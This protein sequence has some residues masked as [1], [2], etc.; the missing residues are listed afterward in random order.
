MALFLIFIG[1]V[2]RIATHF[3]DFAPL[4][5]IL[6]Y[7]PHIPNFAPIAAIA[8]FGSVY[9]NKKYALVLPLLAMLISDI[10]IGFYSP[11]IMISVYSSFLLIGLIGL[12]L[13]E[14]K[15][16]GNILGGSLF[17][18][19]IFFLVTNFAMWAIP[20]SLYPHTLQ[21]LINCYTMGL[22]F[23]RYTILGDL[24]YTSVF[25]GSMEVVLYAHQKLIERRL[26]VSTI[27]GRKKV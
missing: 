25:F 2:L 10:F 15:T 16:V 6:K 8:L 7:L 4:A 20:H 12:Y 5:D 22:P 9:L 3:S 13:R 14:H 19:I 21:G 27:M 1:I 17:G 23:F 24:F 26:H 18:S 11:W